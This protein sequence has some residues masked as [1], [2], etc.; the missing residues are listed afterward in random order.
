M[1]K[2]VARIHLSVTC[3]SEHNLPILVGAHVYWFNLH[4]H[5]KA[6]IF[7]SFIYISIVGHACFLDSNLP[8]HR[9]AHFFI[10]LILLSI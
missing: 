2:M 9:D 3:F 7:F 6:H 1:A 4:R 10:S 8:L 5:L